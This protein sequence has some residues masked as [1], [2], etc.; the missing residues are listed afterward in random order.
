MKAAAAAELV[1]VVVVVVVVVAIE[2]AVVSSTCSNS[3]R[4]IHDYPLRLPRRQCRRPPLLLAL[5]PFALLLQIVALLL[6]AESAYAFGLEG[7][8]GF[9][10]RG[11][12]RTAFWKTRGQGRP[13]RKHVLLRSRCETNQ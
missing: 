8:Y 13:V 4:T 12:G 11:A 10:A 5:L 9:S 7:L 1:V 2:G 6:E 3:G